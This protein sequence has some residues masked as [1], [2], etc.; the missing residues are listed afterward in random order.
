YQG[1]T[2]GM[3]QWKSAH[4]AKTDSRTLE[5]AMKGADVV[6]GLSQKGAFSAKMIRSMAE[7]PINFAMANP[8]PEITPEEVARIRDDAI[9]ATGR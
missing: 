5:E 9:M 2:E 4:A 3:N 6:F 8:D 7:R 1:R